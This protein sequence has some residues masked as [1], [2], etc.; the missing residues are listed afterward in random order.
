MCFLPRFLLIF[1]SKLSYGYTL[2]TIRHQNYT[3]YVV[4]R[5]TLINSVL[6]ECLRI[7]V[8]SV[9]KPYYE[10]PYFVKLDTSGK[11]VKSCSSAIPNRKENRLIIGFC[12]GKGF[13]T[14]R[15]PIH[16]IVCVLEQIRRFLVYQS[17]GHLFL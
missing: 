13:V 8:N 17:I 11:Y 1:C 7:Y 10:S 2:T 3:L 14:P 16:R 5:K 15:P 12:F 6:L 9:F 4:V